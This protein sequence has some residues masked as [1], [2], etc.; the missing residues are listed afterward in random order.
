MNRNENTKNMIMNALLLGIGALL[1]QITPA[2]GLPMQP[3]FALAMLFIIMILNRGKYKTCLVAAIIT[4]IFTAMTTKFPGGQV[5]N[6]I[7][8]LVTVNVV[9]LVMLIMNKI[10]VI[11]SMTESKRRT[12]ESLVVF[13][14]G[15][16]VSGLT[17]LGSASLIVGLPAGFTSLFVAVVIP[18]VGLNLVGGMFLFKIISTS[19]KRAFA[20]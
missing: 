20:N 5:P 15:T 17:F 7:D 16:L 9:F 1:H 2:L 8:K 3:D 12:I 6:M 11:K 14:I 13:P 10:N 4:G 18:A 19:M